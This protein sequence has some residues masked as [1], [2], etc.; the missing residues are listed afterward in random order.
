MSYKQPGWTFLPLWRKVC[1][2]ECV[3]IRQEGRQTDGSLPS[4]CQFPGDLFRESSNSC[5]PPTPF[6]MTFYLSI[7]KTDGEPGVLV[8][9]LL[10]VDLCFRLWAVCQQVVCGPQLGV[11]F[12]WVQ[13]PA[14]GVTLGTEDLVSAGGQAPSL[15]RGSTVEWAYSGWLGA[16]NWG[17]CLNPCTAVWWGIIESP[18]LC[19]L[20]TWN[21]ASGIDPPSALQTCQFQWDVGLK[22]CKD[23][24]TKPV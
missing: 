23:K 6:T 14:V 24:T 1:V 9:P 15:W 7:Q 20:L 8:T 22:F 12:L 13:R 4:F 11:C 3:T 2:W 10:G 18:C 19:S 16:R 5:Y 21:R 17:F